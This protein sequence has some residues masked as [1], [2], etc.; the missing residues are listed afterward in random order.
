MVFIK[1]NLN[2]ALKKICVAVIG[3]RD[4]SEYGMRW[5]ERLGAYLAKKGLGVVSGLALGCDAEGHKGCL[6]EKGYALA[7]LAHGLDKIH[8]AA[9][10]SL[11]EEILDSG[12]CLL[13]EYP[14]GMP[15][16]RNFFV[17]R[18]R[19]QS[20]MSSGVIIVETDIKGGSMHT[21]SFAIEQQRKLAC[22]KHPEKYDKYPKAQGNISLISQ[23]KAQPILTEEDLQIF[24]GGLKGIHSDINT[25]SKDEN[26]TELK[27]SKKP[28]QLPIFK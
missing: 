28:E 12:G 2:D 13:S 6:Q 26:T 1:G 16:Q 20:G 19:L 23:G 11:G 24:L 21:A 4:P 3:T 5:A 8:P 15:P 27:T 17:E 18:D 9:N 10:R 7:V 25:T 14:P 22:L